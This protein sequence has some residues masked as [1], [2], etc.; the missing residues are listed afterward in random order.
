MVT[1]FCKMNCV[2][3]PSNYVNI[4]LKFMSTCNIHMLTSRILISICK[5]ILLI[6][7]LNYVE[8]QH[9]YVACCHKVNINKLLI[10]IIYLAC[11][12]QKY[13]TILF[14]FVC[15]IG[16]FRP[17]HSRI[18]QSYGEVTITGQGLQIF[19]IFPALMT[20]EQ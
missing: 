4:R 2:N 14:W 8:C 18:S 12:V 17:M 20:I 6:C 10:D 16:V 1:Y 9:N 7:K 13:A 5:I 11:R 3:I 15:L 19:N